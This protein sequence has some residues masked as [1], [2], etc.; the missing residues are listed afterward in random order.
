MFCGEEKIGE[1]R[2]RKFSCFHQRNYHPSIHLSVRGLRPDDDNREI[3]NACRQSYKTQLQTTAP[4]SYESKMEETTT[5]LPN[6]DA[7]RQPWTFGALLVVAIPA[8]VCTLVILS[9]SFSHWYTMVKKSL[10]HHAVLLL[11]VLSLLYTSFDLPFSINYFRLGY[12]SYRSIPFCLWWYWFD[13]SL[14]GM[15]LFLTATASIQRHILIFHSSWLKLR[16]A[17]I[18]LHYVPLLISMTYPPL[19]YIVLMFLYP[20]EVYFD[21]SEGWCAYPCYLDN[22]VLFNVDWVA[23][24]IVPVF[25]IALANLALVIRVMRSMKKIR[26]HQAPTWK[27]QKRLTLQLFA[28]S[29]LYVI[30]F[31]PTSLLAIIHVLALPNLY[32]DMPNLYYMFHMIYFVCPIQSLLCIFALPELLNFIKRLQQRFLRRKL[33]VPIT[34]IRV[35]T[36]SWR[37]FSLS[38]VS[39]TRI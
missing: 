10:H 15:S 27:R 29:F 33:V 17:R 22:A 39:F 3:M 9:F 34:S 23:N 20:C 12:H 11:I 2:L 16:W 18:L 31:V 1:S 26:H 38:S 14:I 6:F 4:L 25:T 24:N 30:V 8:L 37:T 7:Y 32:V 13:Y 19:F 21:I 36:N 35:R 5:P 28:F